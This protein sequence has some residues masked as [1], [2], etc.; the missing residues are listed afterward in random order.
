MKMFTLL[1]PKTDE[2]MSFKVSDKNVTH[3][4]FHWKNGRGS[5]T[6]KLRFATFKIEIMREKRNYLI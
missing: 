3:P 5:L 4:F 2:Y 6:I 1:S